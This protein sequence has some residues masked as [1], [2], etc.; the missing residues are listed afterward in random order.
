VVLLIFGFVL[1]LICDLCCFKIKVE[2]CQI[3]FRGYFKVICLKLGL[4]GV[5]LEEGFCGRIIRK[6]KKSTYNMKI[7]NSFVG[8]IMLASLILQAF[9]L[10][11]PAIVQ[12]AG[13]REYENPPCYDITGHTS[14]VPV[15]GVNN[16]GILDFD[17]TYTGPGEQAC[18]RMKADLSGPDHLEGWVWN[19][20][21]GWVSLYCTGGAG[22]KGQNLGIGCGSHKYKVDF[23]TSGGVWPNYT[24]VTMSGYA[25]GDN[26]G[27]ISFDS[28]F[29]QMS[30][31]AS[32]ASRGL[33][34]P[35]SSADDRHAWA[36]TVGWLDWS[37]VWFHWEDTDP[38]VVDPDV[39]KYISICSSKDLIPYVLIT[40]PKCTCDLDGTCPVIVDENKIPDANG[41]DKYDI[42]IPFVDNNV[43][44]PDTRI[45]QCDATSV[46]LTQTTVGGKEYCAR[47][48]LTWEDGVDYNQTLSTSQ[49]QTA[50]PFGTSNTGA[51]RKPIGYALFG[52]SA[53]DF[54][55]VPGSELWGANVKSFAPTSERNSFDGM[56]NEKFYFSPDLSG[57][58]PTLTGQNV[59]KLKELKLL[60]FK[61]GVG[62]A[63]GECIYGN[64][65]DGKCEMRN[66][67]KA[68]GT[69]LSFNPLLSADKLSYMQGDK[70]LNFINI[71]SPDLA[72][73]FSYNAKVKP[74][75]NNYSL[76]MKAGLQDDAVYRM[77]FINKTF[78]VSPGD[79]S[80]DAADSLFATI[81]AGI[82]QAQ[83]FADS[84][85]TTFSPNAGPYVYTIAKYVTG[86]HDIQY[87]STKLPRVKAGLLL[88]PVAKIQGNVYV[89]D[90][91]Q[92]ASDVSLRSLGNVSS[93]LRREA[94]VRN[95][96]R[97]LSGYAVP[98]S[99]GVSQTVSTGDISAI[100]GLNEL[101]ND[102]VFY[103]KDAN[104]TIECPGG[105]CTFNKNVTFIVENGNIFVNS[106]LRTDGKSQIGLIA[107]RNLDRNVKNQGFIYLD[108]G[109]TWLQNTQIYVDRV[110]QS[111][112]KSILVYD[113][114][115][116][117]KTPGDDYERQQ[118]FQNQLVIEGTVSSMNGIGN[119]S[120]NPATDENGLKAPGSGF[121][122]NYGEGDLAG[123]CRARVVDLNYLRY[124]GPGLE[125]CTGS[126][127]TGA[128]ANV[129]RDQALRS[130]VAAGGGCNPAFAGYDVDA[131]NL[132]DA[133]NTTDLVSGGVSGGKRS[134]Y[135]T[136]KNL[137]KTLV[138]EF[139]VNFFY[140]PIAKDLAGFE[141]D[142]AIN[143]LL[144][145]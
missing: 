69:T 10:S 62:G 73:N 51:T 68:G 63:Q 135:F 40:D 105:S 118:R 72:L 60:F 54:V 1:P 67:M 19:D 20:N 140:K 132:Y 27:W 70:A 101:V 77:K 43:K 78:P 131:S 86:G 116:F 35:S 79:E 92:K 50:N 85:G 71:T 36:E 53:P 16:G 97:Y 13:A 87:F 59:L 3:K 48:E 88:N 44:I 12:A 119:A 124:Y 17:D 128:L 29:H 89:T 76:E 7:K 32:G 21:L 114:N 22:D 45:E 47:M 95:V 94:V 122:S 115:G 91:G 5:L 24:N 46:S 109:V 14:S 64:I 90:L 110:L 121:C 127:G 143:P 123:I 81:G 120:R 52:G 145:N 137:P 8:K 75:A 133:D 130:N 104:L 102:K 100:A 28:K 4:F 136:V 9:S 25:W 18:V 39:L 34:S 108:K 107:I 117:A 41:I 93:N 66:Y 23:K 139:P 99:T 33:I 37:G 125:I 142:Q 141:V 83:L 129:P 42:E 96:A 55:Y 126:E 106:D 134:L 15:E 49:N 84:L 65:K 113:A 2:V 11:F 31:M 80:K 61:Y 74:E 38:P 82:K 144:Q 112:D 6:T 26:I 103:V 57:Y 98:L 56:E 58:N 111:Y 138:N 30:P